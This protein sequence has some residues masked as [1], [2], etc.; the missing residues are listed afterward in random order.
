[1]GTENGRLLVVDSHG[2]TSLSVPYGILHAT[3]AYAP[4]IRVTLAR[5]M[6]PSG[7]TSATAD[8]KLS[9]CPGSYQTPL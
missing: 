9:R 6:L 7:H 3:R 2:F 8:S 5:Y 4:R 1:M